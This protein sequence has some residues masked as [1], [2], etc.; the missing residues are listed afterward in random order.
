M[1]L[2]TKDIWSKCLIKPNSKIKE[3]V[4]SLSKS[5]LQI[6]LV[7]SKNKTL[8]GT[9]TDGDVRRGLLRGLSLE[10]SITSLIKKNPFVVT[11]SMNNNTI[12]YFMRSKSLLQVPRVN[13]K[14]KVTG[15][16][17]FNDFKL[18]KKRKNLVVI[19]AGG[20]GKRLRPFT[21][22]CPKPML[23]VGGSP[24]LEHII[25]NISN[26]GFSKILISTH[27]LGSMIKDYF[28]DGKNFNVEIDYIKES[29]PM[30]TAG[31]LSLMKKIPK[32]PFVIV[33]GDILTDI[34][35]GDLIDYHQKNRSQ[36][37]MAVKFYDLKNPYGVVKTKGIEIVDFEEKPVQKSTIINAGV[38][39]LNPATIKSLK[40]KKLD[41]PDFF[42]TIKKKR[43]KTVVFP[44]YENWSEIGSFQDYD[45]IKKTERKNDQ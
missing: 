14:F 24:I 44:I 3:A 42:K 16:Y 29:K 45:P 8:I 1:N 4:R 30:G 5:T 35:Y 18:L 2:V 33:N 28:K 10:D 43:K 32:E 17:L 34:N 9:I 15:L 22:K 21:L 39:V 20:F 37:T 41:M 12:Q 31:A 23:T 25:N 13:K 40:K 38:Y 7:V 19:M 27:Y 26:Q 11:A 6:C 36:A